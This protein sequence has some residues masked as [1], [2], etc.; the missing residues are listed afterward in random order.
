MIKSCSQGSQAIGI[1]YANPRCN[2]NCF[3]LLVFKIRD[4]QREDYDLNIKMSLK[5]DILKAWSPAGS[6]VER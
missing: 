4:R 1:I 5:V 6:P 3:F 2:H